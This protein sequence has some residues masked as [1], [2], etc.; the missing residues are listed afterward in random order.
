[1]STK[2]VTLQRRKAKMLNEILKHDDFVKATIYR[3]RRKGKEGNF[4]HLT[5]KDENQKTHTKYISEEERKKAENAIDSMQ[6]VNKLIN[7][8][9]KI[10]IELIKL[11]D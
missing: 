9:S 10:N 6:S 8:V 7:E 2:K 4:Y 5:Y 11:T 1:M 3:V